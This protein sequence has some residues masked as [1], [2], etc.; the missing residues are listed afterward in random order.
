[1]G[2]LPENIKPYYLI[3]K[4]RQCQVLNLKITGIKVIKF[5]RKKMKKQNNILTLLKK[6]N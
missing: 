1:M 3:N 4:Q 6:I 2:L 5:I